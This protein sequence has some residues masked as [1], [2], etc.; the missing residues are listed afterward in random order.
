MR[1]P[2]GDSTHTRQSPSSSR[3]RSTTMVRRVGNGARRPPSDRAGTAAGSRRRAR[4]RSCSRVSRS[5]RGGRRAAAAGRASAGRWRGRARAAGRRGRLSRT[6]SCPA[7]PGAGETSTRSC[8]IS[9]IRHDEAPSTNVSPTR[10][11][12]TISSSSSPTRARARAGAERGR[13]RTARGR[14]SCRRWRSPRASRLRAPTTVPA[15][16]SHVTRGPQLGELVGRIAAREH[17]EHAVEHGAAQLGE[18]RGAPDRREQL[19]D[20]PVVHRRH[21]HDLL[22]DDVE[23][24]AGIAG[25]FDRAVVH[26]LARPPR[27]RRGRRGTSGR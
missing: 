11:S 12:K 24:V 16:R 4:S 27:R 3:T 26:R 8:V 1:P 17:V 10:L 14:E 5:T 6:A 21:R 22:R 23:R 19:V 18:R 13:R 2:R 20:V 25:R 9:S 15:T 7:R